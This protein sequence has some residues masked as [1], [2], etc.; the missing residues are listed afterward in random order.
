MTEEIKMTSDIGIFDFT[1]IE[2][3]EHLLFGSGPDMGEASLK[4]LLKW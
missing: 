3:V 1:G 2:T 4:A